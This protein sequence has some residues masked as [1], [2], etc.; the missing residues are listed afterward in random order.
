MATPKKKWFID[1][2]KIRLRQLIR[3]PGGFISL[4]SWASETPQKLW[5]HLQVGALPEYWLPLYTNRETEL[6]ETEKVA[7]IAWQRGNTAGQYLKD[8][9]PPLKGV[10][11]TLSY[12]VQ[13][14]G[15]DQLMDNFLIGGWWGNWESAA[16]TFWF[17]LFWDLYAYGQHT[18]NFFHPA[19]TSASAKQLQEP[20]LAHHL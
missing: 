13:G 4:T 6:E 16:S 12:A 18:V 3:N 11:R 20:G 2:E 15:C 17:Q 10:V 9:L 14:A 19:G 5:K 7:L 1:G 8:C